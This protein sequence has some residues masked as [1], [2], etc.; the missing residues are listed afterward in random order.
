MFEFFKIAV[1]IL[2]FVILGIFAGVTY[3]LATK[4]EDKKA[5]GLSIFIMVVQAL[6]IILLIL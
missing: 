4:Q 1:I 6:E 5:L 3:I 2:A